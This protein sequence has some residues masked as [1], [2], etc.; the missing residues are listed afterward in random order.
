MI[1]KTQTEQKTVT[2]FE[3]DWAALAAGVEELVLDHM[4]SQI[5][6]WND[7]LSM[8]QMAVMDAADGLQVC[9]HLLSG[10]WGLARKRLFDMDTAAR[11]YVFDFIEVVAGPEFFDCVK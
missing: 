2:T 10:H 7:D 5:E 11:D 6:H 4:N 1:V 3:I 8:R 9:E